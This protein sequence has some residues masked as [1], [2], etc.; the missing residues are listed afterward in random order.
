MGLIAAIIASLAGLLG[1]A[2]LVALLA[3]LHA[4]GRRLQRL[5]GAFNRARL[6]RVTRT[7]HTRY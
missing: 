5:E 4:A 6:Y 1:L 7:G 3:R 2:T